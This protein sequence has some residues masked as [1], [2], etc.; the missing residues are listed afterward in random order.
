[1]TELPFE[2][3]GAETDEADRLPEP[4]GYI[5]LAPK[6]FAVAMNDGNGGLGL[7]TIIIDGGLSRPRRH[8]RNEAKKAARRAKRRDRKAF[9]HR[10]QLTGRP[11]REWQ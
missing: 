1:M 8:S 7:V 10:G 5:E 11:K 3:Y 2:R 9:F 6:I 4:D